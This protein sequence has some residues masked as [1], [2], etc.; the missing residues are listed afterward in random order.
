M[1]EVPGLRTSQ[2]DPIRIDVLDLTRLDVAPS[3]RIGLTIAPGKTARRRN[4]ARDRE[5]DLARLRDDGFE[6]VPI[7]TPLL[8]LTREGWKRGGEISVF[9]IPG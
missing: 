9:T 4:W 2:N 3:G 7:A 1:S 5:V 8:W 6:R